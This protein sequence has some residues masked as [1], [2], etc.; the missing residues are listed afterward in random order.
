MHV[1][2]YVTIYV[3]TT[4][5]ASGVFRETL[6]LSAPYK[7]LDSIFHSFQLGYLCHSFIGFFGLETPNTSC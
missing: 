1:I 6:R 5:V 3:E 2:L 4:V 7:S